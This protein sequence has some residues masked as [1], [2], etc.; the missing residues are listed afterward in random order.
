M[1][2]DS[3]M[4]TVDG[5][6]V[7]KALGGGRLIT[8]ASA[9][10]AGR[11][12]PRAGHPGR[13]YNSVP[14]YPGGLYP[15]S[16][17]QEVVPRLLNQRGVQGTI[18][19]LVLQS[20][21]SDITNLRASVPEAQHRGYVEQSARDMVSIME[22]ALTHYPALRQVIILEQL[23]RL[24]SPH[25]SS[26]GEHYNSILR[27]LVTSSPHAQH[28]RVVGHPT[29]SPTYVGRRNGLFGPPHPRN[30]GI[31]FRGKEG[32]RRHTDSVVSALRVAGIASWSVQSRRGAARPSSP[33]Y[34]QVV[35]TSNRFSVLN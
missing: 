14:G 9:G 11:R 20:P 34:S 18:T 3:T 16:S 17:F 4:K 12:S 28:I 24:D 35:Q 21:T 13:A 26:L 10:T 15:D 5:A 6:Q 25:L 33:S 8:G 2:G 30:D 29:L 22:R 1:I 31:H 7:R 32:V 27:T 23:P 19:N